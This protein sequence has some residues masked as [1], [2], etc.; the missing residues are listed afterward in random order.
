M[1]VVDSISSHQQLFAH[2][3]RLDL[4]RTLV[5]YK[6]PTVAALLAVLLAVLSASAESLP[7]PRVYAVLMSCSGMSVHT[8]TLSRKTVFIVPTCSP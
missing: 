1:N 7:Q 6:Y 2:T 4:E 8:V 5:M 3:R